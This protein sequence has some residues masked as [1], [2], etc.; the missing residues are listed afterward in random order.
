MLVTDMPLLPTT[1]HALQRAIEDGQ[2][3]RPAL[4]GTRPEV[5]DEAT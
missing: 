1:E 4:G 3:V 5:E 2:R